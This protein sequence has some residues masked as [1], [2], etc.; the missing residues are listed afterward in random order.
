MLAIDVT[1]QHSTYP[2]IQQL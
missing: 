2:F 1:V